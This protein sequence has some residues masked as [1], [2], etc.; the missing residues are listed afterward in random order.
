[1]NGTW[2]TPREVWLSAGF[3]VAAGALEIGLALWRLPQPLAFW[4]VWEALSRGL[5]HFLVAVGLWRRLSLCR[6]IAIAYCAAALVTYLGAIALAL[7]GVADRFPLSVI[8]QSLF[9]I[10]SCA[11]L[12][13]YL[14]SPRASVI[15]PRPLFG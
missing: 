1:M 6:A 3:F 12:L 2:P 14:R 7:A 8:V 15:F 5:L 13:P 11:L 10:P 4:S 9:Q